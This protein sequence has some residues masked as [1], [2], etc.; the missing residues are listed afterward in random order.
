MSEEKNEESV[1][2]SEPANLDAKPEKSALELAQEEANKWKNDYLYL[3]AE[4]DNFRKHTIKE[5]NDLIKYGAERFIR[6]F[7]EVVDNFERALSSAPTSENIASYAAG[8]EM[9]AKEIKTLLAKHGVTSED[10]KGHPFDPSKHEALGT[11]PTNECKS[12]HI[13]RVIRAPY[14]FHDKLLRP[15]QVIVASELK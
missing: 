7:L 15:A 6:D 9:I 10:C 4:F 2:N 3:R 1:N 12:G 5:R 11:E 14:K 13:F 8:I